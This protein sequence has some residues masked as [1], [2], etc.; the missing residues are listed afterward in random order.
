[1]AA[2]QLTPE[3]KKE[4]KRALLREASRRYRLAHPEKCSALV[5]DYHL[6]NRAKLLTN[7]RE[8]YVANREDR[9]A[10]RR[11]YSLSNAE[12]E[13]ALNRQWHLNHREESRARARKWRQ[14][15][16]E[17]IS[18]Q[19]RNTKAR[20]KAAPG[21][22]TADDIRRLFEVQ[23]GICVGCSGVLIRSGKGKMHVDHVMPLALGG[24]NWPENLQ[25]LCPPC[26]LSKHAQHPTTWVASRRIA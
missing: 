16:P 24:S 26:N 22:H 17:A 9:L 5:R 3:E 14:L 23:R 8:R 1:M 20:R 18:T 11:M 13:S 2:K 4:R 7:M 15:N 19:N 12:K 21:K 25:L 10:Y 6:A